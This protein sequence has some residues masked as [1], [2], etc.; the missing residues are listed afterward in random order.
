MDVTQQQVYKLIKQFSG[1]TNVLTI[2]RVFIELTGS[3]HLAALLLSQV[4]YWSERTNDPDGWFYKSYKDWHDE[5]GLSQFQVSRAIKKL[6]LLGVETSLRHAGATKIPVMHYRVNGDV[7]TPF[8]IKFLHNEEPS[9]SRNLPVHNEET[10]QSDYQVSSQSLLIAKTTKAKTTTKITK[11]EADEPPPA[12][13]IKFVEDFYRVRFPKNKPPGRNW[14][15]EHTEQFGQKAVL[16][17]I[18]RAKARDKPAPHYISAI[19]ST[20]S[21]D[22]L[23]RYDDY[24]IL[25]PVSTKVTNI[26][27]PRAEPAATRQWSEFTQRVAGKPTG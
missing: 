8:I 2:P 7:F 25:I 4:I 22:E 9:Q 15:V 21:P 3:D 20:L 23:A 13:E 5:L 16:V 24:G 18:A 27:R 19:I 12:P 14:I 1:Q 11:R 6:G 26:S 17:G 10:S